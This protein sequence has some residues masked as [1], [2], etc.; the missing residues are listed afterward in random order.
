MKRIALCLFTLSALAL[1][2]SSTRS[3]AAP[4]DKTGIIDLKNEGTTRGSC[5]AIGSRLKLATNKIYSQIIRRPAQG[6]DGQWKNQKDAQEIN[7]FGDSGSYWANALRK[8]ASQHVPP[9][10]MNDYLGAHS[11]T[12][13]RFDQAVA[14]DPW[15]GVSAW[16]QC[17]QIYGFLK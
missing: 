1:V 5:A 7:Q 15:I 17:G 4:F 8:G 2:L 10:Q 6:T 13:Q 9:S 12:V 3:Y 16:N 14:K 11:P